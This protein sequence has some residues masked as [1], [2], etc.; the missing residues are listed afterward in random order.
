MKTYTYSEARQNFASILKTA[1]R[2]G[3]IRIRKRNG[4]L[5][6]LKR[7]ETKKSPLD[8]EGINIKIKSDEIVAILKKSRER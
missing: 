3:E 6:V 5:Y 4:Q 2:E 7:A 8:V 1:D